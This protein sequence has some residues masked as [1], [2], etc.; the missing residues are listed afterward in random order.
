MNRHA[1]AIMFACLMMPGL[2]AADETKDVLRAFSKMEARVETGVNYRDYGN[3]LRDLNFEFKSYEESPAADPLVKGHLSL[4]MARYKT[5]A[6]MWSLKFA[7]FRTLAIARGTELWL[8]T[9]ASY[10]DAMRDWDRGGAVEPN[11]GDLIIDLL[12]P[13]EWRAAAADIQAAKTAS[14][15]EVTAASA[16]PRVGEPRVT[17]PPRKVQEPE[18][19]RPAVS[20]KAASATDLAVCASLST[21][22][23]GQKCVAMLK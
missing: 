5:A 21:P 4:A 16:R 18:P 12:L 9:A 15:G 17:D 20:K 6:S 10:P 7:A 14:R 1:V 13:F 23:V 2:C 8:S 11:T 19:V 3:A 22:E